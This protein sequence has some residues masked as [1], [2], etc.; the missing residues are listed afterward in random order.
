MTIFTKNSS[1]RMQRTIIIDDEA[2]IRESLA[3]MLR[4]NC[5]NAKVVAMADGVQSGLKAIKTHRPNLL[6]LD[7]RMKDGT[8]FDLL[9]KLESIDFRIIFITAFDQY[10]IKA[11]KFSA[12]DYLLKPVESGDLKAAVDKADKLSQKEINTQLNTLVNNLQTDEQAKKKII[13]KTFDNIHLVKIKDIL[14]IESDGRYST[15]YLLPG[16]KVIISEALKYYHEMLDDA[17]FFRVHKSFLINLEYIQ[18]FEKAEGGYVIL[19]GGA[20]V[21]VA[22]RKRE[23]LLELFDRIGG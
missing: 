12:L 7:I 17:G 15:F 10:A 1:P 13:L 6:L 19:E 11:F 9:E 22:S 21:P 18:R 5:P 8:G 16:D 2:H 3:D 4:S 20:K 23:D 14:Y